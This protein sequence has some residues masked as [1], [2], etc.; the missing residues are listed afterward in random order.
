MQ[1]KFD[2]KNVN[3]RKVVYGVVSVVL[4]LILWMYVT[5]V[6]G[7]LTTEPSPASR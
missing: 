4:A 1:N 5:N 7:D 2:F 3:V 6:Q